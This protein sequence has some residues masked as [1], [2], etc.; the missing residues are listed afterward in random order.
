MRENTKTLYVYSANCS[1]E[2][3]KGCEAPVSRAHR[4]RQ[5]TQRFSFIA[6]SVSSQV[7]DSMAVLAIPTP[8]ARSTSSS[9]CP[10]TPIPVRT[11]SHPDKLKRRKTLVN[12]LKLQHYRGDVQEIGEQDWDFLKEPTLLRTRIPPIETMFPIIGQLKDYDRGTFIADLIAGL[13]IAFVLI[14]QAIAFSG[15]A[16]VEPITALTSAVFPVIIYALFGASKHLAVGPEALSSVLVG[17]AVEEYVAEFGADRVAVTAGLTFLVGLFLLLLAVLQAGFIDNVLSGYLLTGFVLGVAT[18]IMIEQLPELLGLQLHHHTGDISTF[19]KAKEVFK[20]MPT[21]HGATIAVGLTSFAFLLGFKFL[22]RHFGKKYAWI[23]SVPEILVLVST[24]LVLSCTLDF[25][26]AGI[27]TLGQFDNKIKAPQF[28]GITF[29][30]VKH[31]MSDVI[32]ITIVGFIEC[33]TVTRN[34]GLKHGYFP[35]GNQELFAL[36][37]SNVV[38]SSLGAY[39]TFG[40]LPRSRIQ[41]NAGGKTVVTGIIAAIIVLIAFSFFAQVL[42]FLPRSALAAIVFNAAVNLIEYHEIIYL[43]KMGIWSDVALF[44]VTWGITLFFTMGDGI[45]L[46][47]LLA[48]LLILRRTTTI[49]LN[50]LGYLPNSGLTQN[51]VDAT[52]FP[53]A[54]MVDGALI[55]GLR[56]SLRFYNAGQLRRTM[57]LLMQRERDLFNE[58]RQ[59]TVM[60]GAEE[61]YHHFRG[62][63][64]D[65]DKTP[66]PFKR[67]SDETDPFEVVFG[68][69][70]FDDQYPTDNRFC[71]ILDFSTCSDMVSF[72]C[73]NSLRKLQFKLTIC[74]L[75]GLCLCLHFEADCNKSQEQGRDSRYIYGDEIIAQVLDDKVGARPNAWSEQS[76]HDSRRG[77]CRHLEKKEE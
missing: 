20:V 37:M 68:I 53:E 27:R 52:E 58:E 15:L 7:P 11:S 49:N 25:K 70:D 76:V 57:E 6:F 74:F 9:C 4:I 26:S 22:K 43:F 54:E 73:P 19:D 5:N 45:L 13:T 8:S 50:L 30:M 16:G 10:P 60:K 71:V 36:G 12:E 72:F 56:G 62:F 67:I 28:P 33:Q 48:V 44:I 34:Y 75:K 46:C 41:V 66:T 42:S 55:M 14:P 63:Y 17:I 77:G 1:L 61:D 51:F 3:P 35:S 23:K 64:K 59:Q 47:L 69:K 31:L 21:A 24:M 29:N 32:T 2:T 40:S 39:V 65:V 18:L 38:G